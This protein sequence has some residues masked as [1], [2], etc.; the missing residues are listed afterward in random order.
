MGAEGGEGNET[1]RTTEPGGHGNPGSPGNPE[2]PRDPGRP[3]TPA[4][5]PVGTRLCFFGLSTKQA[6]VGRTLLACRGWWTAPPP[7]V[8]AEAD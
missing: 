1:Q 6:S 5:Q 8:P 2:S 4:D 3:R 7:L